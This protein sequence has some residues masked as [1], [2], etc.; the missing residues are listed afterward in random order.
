MI[1]LALPCGA[2]AADIMEKR[3]LVPLVVDPIPNYNS[4]LP[5][6][7]LARFDSMEALTSTFTINYLPAGADPYG[8]GDNCTAWPAA[9]QTAFEFAVNIWA[10]RLVSTVPITIDACWADNLAAGILGHGGSLSS[11]RNFTNAPAADTWYSVALANAL[12]GSKLNTGG[13]DIYIAYSSTFNWYYGTDGLT[14]VSQMDFMSVVA[15]EMAHGLG[16]AGAMTI[17]GG[18]GSW[19]SFPIIY[20][21][22]NVDGAG[23]SLINTAVYP[24]PSALL[25]TALTSNNV[26]FTG[27]NAKSANGG[28]NVKLYAPT[29]WAQGSSYSH[30][31]Y[32][33]FTATSNA[34]MVYAL[35]YGRAIHDPGVVTMGLLQD[36]G[37]TTASSPVNGICGSANTQAF[38]VAPAANL[39]S[40]GNP[41]ALIGIGPWFWS[42][43]GLNGGS[44]ANCMAYSTSQQSSVSSFPQNF[45]SV[46]APVWPEGWLSTIVSGS[47][48][49]W[50]TNAGTVHPFGVAAHSPVNL[51]YFN[52]Y[53]AVAGASAI[54]ASPVFSLAGKVGGKVDLWMYHDT[55]YNNADRIDVYVNTASNLTGASLLGSANRN[56]GRSGWFLHTF[57]IPPTFNGVTNYLII[58]GVS[59]HGNDIHLDDI[60]VYAF[61]SLYPLA[62]T[63]SGTGY[64]SVNSA[65]SGISCTGT[66]GSACAVTNFAG[67]AT[68]ALSASANASSALNSTFSSW[69]G[70]C[71]G[72]GGC[73]VIM[74]NPFSVTGTFARDRLVKNAQT[75]VVHGTIL[76]ALGLAITGQTIQVRD[77]GSLTPFADALTIDKSIV[78]KGGYDADFTTNAGYTTTSGKI[79]VTGAN[80]VL[81]VHKINIRQ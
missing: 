62:Y 33:T 45:D 32:T 5:A 1:M 50:R 34:L 9:A 79:T 49:F 40:L 60:N 15:H 12:A 65:P 21:R 19:G 3:N 52:S 35:S 6:A 27:A 43:A 56:D 57:S 18:S 78:L 41:S 39:C 11:Y 38:S 28:T 59:A 61:T 26:W 22:F 25:G 42:C 20:D 24:N 13:K 77:N 47:G 81:K 30:L 14:P 17:S 7:P 16:F 46:T 23:Q 66:T 70:A 51:V 63:F 54:L 71:S 76:E 68:V 72:T 48:V 36:L 58:N 31:D 74:N 29:T 67:G 64:G 53:D 75:S 4:V 10:S 37:W 2:T 80:G 8:V 55:G 73:S 69:S 44:S